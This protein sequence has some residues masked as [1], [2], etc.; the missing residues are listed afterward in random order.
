MSGIPS[1][2]VQKLALLH[3]IFNQKISKKSK[4][5]STIFKV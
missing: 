3:A 4:F 2:A 1:A 5:H